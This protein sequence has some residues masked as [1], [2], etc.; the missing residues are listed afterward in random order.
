MTI[1]LWG[2]HYLWVNFLQY[3]NDTNLTLSQRIF[4][5]F[6]DF[7]Q[8]R[9]KKS[10]QKSNKARIKYPTRNLKE[11]D[12]STAHFDGNEQFS[13]AG[14]EKVLNAPVEAIPLR[15]APVPTYTPVFERNMSE[16]LDLTFKNQHV[17]ID[18]DVYDYNDFTYE[19][20]N[21]DMKWIY[22]RGKKLRYNRQEW[23]FNTNYVTTDGRL[24][25]LNGQPW[26]TTTS[27][28]RRKFM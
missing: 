26:K 17:T 22:D 12:I 21:R 15:P 16:L 23:K 10:S 7:F 3:N 6:R 25:L 9:R 5:I 18:G 4:K 24:E 13:S 19:N 20:N 2:L 27:I 28:R 1:I 14:N 11:I 8:Q